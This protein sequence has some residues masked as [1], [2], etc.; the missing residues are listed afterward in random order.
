MCVGTCL[1]VVSVNTPIDAVNVVPE[2]LC[3]ENR[4]LSLS[5]WPVRSASEMDF[6]RMPFFGWCLGSA[7]E[8]AEPRAVCFE[9]CRL[10]EPGAGRNHASRRIDDRKV[11]AIRIGSAAHS[12]LL[13]FLCLFSVCDIM[14]RIDILRLSE[15][16]GLCPFIKATKPFLDLA[17][18]FK[19]IPVVQTM[20]EAKAVIVVEVVRVTKSGIPVGERGFYDRIVSVFCRL[21]IDVEYGCNPYVTVAFLALETPIE[22]NH[23]IVPIGL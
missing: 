15:R 22:L 1:V 6:H 9:N 18:K 14:S 20:S 2:T 21:R 23:T 3:A 19:Q 7:V 5:L 17:E 13:S 8:T 10:L 11:L 4:P 12:A 16:A